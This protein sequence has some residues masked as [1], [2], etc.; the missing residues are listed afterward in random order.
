MAEHGVVHPRLQ[1]NGVQYLSRFLIFGPL[2]ERFILGNQILF[3]LH[4]DPIGF[5]RVSCLF[6]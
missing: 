2:D 4:G 5:F 3:E 1:E 6:E